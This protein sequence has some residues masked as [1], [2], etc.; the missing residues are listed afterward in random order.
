VDCGLNAN[1]YR[2]S[3]VKWLG[4][5]GIFCCE[6]ID[7]HRTAKIKSAIVWTGTLLWPQ[8]LRSTALEFKVLRLPPIHMIWIRRHRSDHERVRGPSNHN[9]S[10]IDPRRKGLLSLTHRRWRRTPTTA[11]PLTVNPARAP[12]DYAESGEGKVAGNKVVAIPRIMHSD[13]PTTTHDGKPRDPWR[14]RAIEE[15]TAG[16]RPPKVV[17]HARHNKANLLG[18]IPRSWL[19]RSTRSTVACFDRPR[20]D[21]GSGDLVSVFARARG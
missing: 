21:A 1:K 9:R 5:R 18:G 19:Q 2:V 11:A 8:D 16:F 15:R 3:L 4:R 12:R 14:R 13:D 17:A 7:L 6:P 20:H 10:S